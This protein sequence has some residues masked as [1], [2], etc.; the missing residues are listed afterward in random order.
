MKDLTCSSTMFR[1]IT[2]SAPSKVIL[3][4]EHAVVYGKSAVAAS[5]DLRTRMYLIPFCDRQP[6][7]LEVDF[8]DVRVKHSWKG[9]DIEDRLLSHRPTSFPSDDIS[10]VFLRLV[11]DFIRETGDKYHEDLQLASL[12]CFFYLYSILCQEFV[13]MRIK[14][15]SDIPI[16]Q[17]CH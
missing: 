11:Q 6:N 17:A 12:T 15:E 16:G 14:V 9:E 4:G 10:S 13:P 7:V 8:P 5:L 3:H 2:V 1:Q